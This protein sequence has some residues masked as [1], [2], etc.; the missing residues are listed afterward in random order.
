MGNRR[1]RII[2]ALRDEVDADQL[3]QAIL[4]MVERQIARE[5]KEKSEGTATGDAA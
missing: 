2:G 3:A 4:A 5:A 1:I